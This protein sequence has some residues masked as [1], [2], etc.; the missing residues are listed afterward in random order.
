MNVGSIVQISRHSGTGGGHTS[1][2]VGLIVQI[3]RHS[4]TGGGRPLESIRGA[5][6]NVFFFFFVSLWVFC[7]FLSLSTG[8]L[9]TRLTS[10]IG[11]T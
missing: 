6:E 10:G 9:G 3:S 7:P 2:K 11:V 5:S 8:F 1:M 4:G